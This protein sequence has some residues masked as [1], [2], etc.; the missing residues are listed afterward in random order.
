MG[1]YGPYVL[2]AYGISFGTV[3]ALIVWAVAGRRA[4]NRA[5]ARAERAARR[6][7]GR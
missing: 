5:L 6:E 4:A 1:E 7:G 3:T 2:A